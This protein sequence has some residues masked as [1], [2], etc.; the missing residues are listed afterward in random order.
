MRNRFHPKGHQVE[1]AQYFGGDL[2]AQETGM[3]ATKVSKLII[4]TELGER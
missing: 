3:R 4:L 2:K 1:H